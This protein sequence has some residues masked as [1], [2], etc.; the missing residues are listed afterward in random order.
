MS[1][2]ERITV[3]VNGRPVEVPPGAPVP[4]VLHAAGIPA[5]RKGIAVALDGAVVPRSQW[6]E[7][8]VDPGAVLE[9]VTA[10]QGG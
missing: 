6:A 8:Q 5:D 3:D 4:D 2:P 9:V 10:T 7:T 1:S